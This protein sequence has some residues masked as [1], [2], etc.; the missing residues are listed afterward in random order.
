MRAGLGTKKCPGLLYQVP[1]SRFD[2]AVAV[3]D[4]LEKKALAL[5]VCSREVS[6]SMIEPVMIKVLKSRFDP[7][8]EDA[9][10]AIGLPYSFYFQVSPASPSEIPLA[11]SKMPT[12]RLADLLGSH[13]SPRLPAA[14]SPACYVGPRQE[15]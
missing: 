9:F 5:R 12:H 1:K 14:E 8:L 15:P 2:P 13:L 6:V 7:S 4:W 10:F 11:T 3:P